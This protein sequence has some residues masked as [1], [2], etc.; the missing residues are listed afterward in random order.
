MA[1]S[2][3]FNQRGGGQRDRAVAAAREHL[4]R[5]ELDQAEALLRPWLDVTPKKLRGARR[6]RGAGKPPKG[7]A[8]ALFL[9]ATVEE[10]RYR[11]TSAERL[12]R[13]SMSIRPQPATRLLLARLARARGETDACVAGCRAVLRDEPDH[14]LAG[15]VLAGALE[16]AGRF[17]DA[18]AAIAPA[19]A[20][21]KVP[22][23]VREVEAKLLVQRK[24]F[25]E[26]VEAIDALLADEPEATPLR[27]SLEHLR[28]KALDRQGDYAGAW[29]AAGRA[30]AIGQLA[31][32]PELYAEQVAELM[33]V[34]SPENVAGFPR[35]ACDSELPVFVAGMP[36]SGTSLIDQV[37]DA[38]PQAAGVGELA[39]IETFARSLAAEF[40][41]DAEPGRQFGGL[42]QRAWDEAA[43]AYVA[44]LRAAGGPD[45]RRVVNKALGNNKLVGL[46]AR[47]FPKTRIIHAIRDPRD[48]AISCYMGGFNNRLHPWTTDAAWA[49]AAWEQSRRMMAHWKATLDVPVL[50]VHYEDL[51]ADPE[52]QFRRIID[53][54]GLPWDEACLGFHRSRRTVRTLSY[55]QVNRPIYKTSAGRH[56]NYAAQIAGIAFPPYRG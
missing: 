20:G 32:E 2:T 41:P 52:P 24:R 34:W 8:E 39:T 27:R 14:P 40:D 31:F 23:A 56:V 19:L 49:A 48:V 6:P 51:V 10:L 12:A 50:D 17:D 26:A 22:W 42:G 45:V 3:S 55:D 46:L 28:A 9:L 13:R 33:R 35:A 29:A 15:A 37:I 16:E 11:L 5:K 36:R 1:S 25:G 43:R 30:N 53:F 7:D 4:K 54:L 38:H 44:E 47:L 21:A 18:E